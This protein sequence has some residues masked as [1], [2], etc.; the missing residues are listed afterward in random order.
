MTVAPLTGTQKAA[1]VLMSM[2]H[3]QAA[4]VLTRFSD[5]EAEE[6]AAEIVRLR[7]V[8]ADVAEGALAEF[9]EAATTG[10]VP[11]R[12]GSDFAAGLLERSFGAER[13]SGFMT[14]VASSM[15]GRSFEFLDELDAATVTGLLEGEMPQTVAVVLAHV[16]PAL[17]SAVIGA[18]PERVG[19]E[20][21]E[22]IATMTSATPE[23]LAI[24][25]GALKTRSAS[26]ASPRSAAE[27]TGGIQP[28]VDI[29]NRSPVAMERAL[30][31]GLE[32]RD[33]QLAHDVRARLLTFDDIVRLQP[34]DVQAVLRRVEI[35]SL[36]I[37]VKNAPSAV[38]AVIESN[39]SERN[40]ALLRDEVSLLGA[41]R[42][43]QIEEARSSVVQAIRA[44]QDEGALVVHRE[45]DE[46][47]G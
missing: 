12:G 26:M 15:A 30:L 5:A 31:D 21:A 24:V 38:V 10:R 22:C 11:S 35:P 46:L 19:V 34:R 18:L 16:Q 4:A 33:P 2:N 1:V 41:V 42:V 43:S 25:S 7:R 45:E 47:V 3:D 6:I 44:M 28:L 17:A 8:D 40:R 13:A 29:I 32:Q 39:L 14:R 23:A 27:V 36:A 20:I 37:A 9:H